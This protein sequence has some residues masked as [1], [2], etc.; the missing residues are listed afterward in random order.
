MIQLKL[1]LFLTTTIIFDQ[2]FFYYKDI[3][4]KNKSF[5]LTL[6]K[7]LYLI[8]FSNI[9]QSLQSTPFGD[10]K[11]LLNMISI[12]L[13]EMNSHFPSHTLVMESKRLP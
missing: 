12:E 6:S 3:S 9:C 5:L 4:H 2:F 10:H 13:E 11:I 1:L 8:Y 7:E